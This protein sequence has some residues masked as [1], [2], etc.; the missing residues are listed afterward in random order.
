MNA[1][2]F[3]PISFEAASPDKAPLRAK[4]G[5]RRPM[6]MAAIR[7]VNEPPSPLP[8]LFLSDASDE[9]ELDSALLEEDEMSF[10]IGS[11]MMV[12]FCPND[13]VRTHNNDTERDVSFPSDLVFPYQMGSVPEEDFATRATMLEKLSS[14]PV[15]FVL[16]IKK[17]L[18]VPAGWIHAL[19][20]VKEK[21]GGI[22]DFVCMRGLSSSGGLLYLRGQ[23]CEFSGLT[24][25]SNFITDSGILEKRI[26]EQI[27]VYRGVEG[28]RMATRRG[29][30]K[31]LSIAL[32]R[33]TPE[34]R[35]SERVI[36]GWMCYG[37]PISE[38]NP[39]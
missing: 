11:G 24:H 8:E 26:C 19:R 37:R 13:F 21:Y 1:R 31:P 35:V 22:F 16:Q 20:E 34:P 28:V 12:T 33:K 2:N 10:D 38:P 7:A 25:D 32:E 4:G 17:G 15:V 14:V 27:E 3:R 30:E 23:V 39:I 18:P 9:V 36:D 6:G 5:V 29:V